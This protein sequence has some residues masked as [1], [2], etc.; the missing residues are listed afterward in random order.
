MVTDGYVIRLTFNSFSLEEAT[1]CIFDYVQVYDNST[2]ALSPDMGRYV[3]LTLKAVD[4]T[5]INFKKTL[6]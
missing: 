2:N 6:T 3:L 5:G 4:T 1:D